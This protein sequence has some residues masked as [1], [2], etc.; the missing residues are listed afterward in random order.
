MTGVGGLCK[1]IGWRPM[2]CANRGS[3]VSDHNVEMVPSESEKWSQ[4]LSRARKNESG[5]INSVKNGERPKWRANRSDKVSGHNVEIVPSES[6]KWSQASS[7]ARKNESGDIKNVKNGERPKWHAN[8]GNYWCLKK[9]GKKW[10][11][12]KDATRWPLGWSSRANPN[13]GNGSEYIFCQGRCV[14]WK[15]NIRPMLQRLGWE[16]SG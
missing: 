12:Q 1:I 13:G 10:C 6:E 4:A 9:M 14:R 2:W 7:R 11:S 5:D 15:E 3:K 16:T 8:R